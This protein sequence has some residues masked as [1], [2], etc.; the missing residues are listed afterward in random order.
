MNNVAKYIIC[1][2]ASMVIYR[3]NNNDNDS[4]NISQHIIA[5]SWLISPAEFSTEIL[6]LL[7]S[8]FPFR[9]SLVEIVLLISSFYCLVAFTRILW[10]SI[11][12]CTFETA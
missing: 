10:P 11:Q 7:S 9:I 12:C 3:C 4:R 6:I 2:N 1:L 8:S 5:V